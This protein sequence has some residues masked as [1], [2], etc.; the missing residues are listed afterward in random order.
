MMASTPQSQARK[1]LL[2]DDDPL[3]LET[4]RVILQQAGYEVFEATSGYDAIILA[5]QCTFDLAMLDAFM[6]GMSGLELAQQLQQKY[7][8]PF[9]F[10]SGSSET[11]L[12]KQATAHGAI[13]YLVKPFDLPQVLPAVQAALAR[14]DDIK[15]LRQSEN[16]LM[17][18]LHAAR[19]TSMAVGLLM[20]KFKLERDASFDILRAYSRSHRCKIHDVAKDLLSAEELINRFEH[21]SQKNILEHKSAK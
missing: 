3:M 11:E 13:G 4:M 15:Q 20:A 1:I 7:S 9:M 12:V 18:A 6:P 5:Q 21:L 2:V 14:G 8:L 19:E 10:V 16:D 17:L